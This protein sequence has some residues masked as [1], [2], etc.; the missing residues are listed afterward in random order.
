MNNNY[1]CPTCNHILNEKE[2]HDLMDKDTVERILDFK[3]EQMCN[4]YGDCSYVSVEVEDIEI[5]CPNC[6]EYNI[7]EYIN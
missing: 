5:K 1:K 3:F 6:H 4:L 2:C 7:F